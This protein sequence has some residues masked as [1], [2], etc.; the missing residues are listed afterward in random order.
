MSPDNRLA[1]SR[2]TCWNPSAFAPASICNLRLHTYNCF[3]P[4]FLL[5][6]NERHWHGDFQ[7]KK[8]ASPCWVRPRGGHVFTMSSRFLW[9]NSFQHYRSYEL[10]NIALSPKTRGLGALTGVWYESFTALLEFQIILTHAVKHRSSIFVL[11][12]YVLQCC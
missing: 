8:K 5:W 7:V 10:D 12:Y 3:V 4:P 11:R 2:C 6:G 9:T 1:R